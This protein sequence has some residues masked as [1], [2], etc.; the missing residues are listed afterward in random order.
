MT[1]ISHPF[2]RPLFPAVERAA[3][4]GAILNFLQLLPRQATA[5][6][7]SGA[8]HGDGVIAL[9]KFIE[10]V[11]HQGGDRRV[12]PLQAAAAVEPEASGFE[13]AEFFESIEASHFVDRE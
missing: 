13:E 7:A 12:D 10:A 3:S 11:G 9:E 1:K 8:S 2:P 5:D 4:A 6:A